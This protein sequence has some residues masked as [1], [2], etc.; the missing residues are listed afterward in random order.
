MW[1]RGVGVG[2]AGAIVAGGDVAVNVGVRMI[3]GAT[4]VAVE[5]GVAGAA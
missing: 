4:A 2:V 3:F 5:V 1:G